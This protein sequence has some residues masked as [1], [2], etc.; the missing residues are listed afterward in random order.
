VAEGGAVELTVLVDRGRGNTAATGEALTVALS[1]APGDAAQASTYRLAPD[2]VELPAVTPPDGSQS[3]ATVV[4]LEA[5][6][7]E[8]VNDD[9][10]TLSLVTTGEAAFGTGSV[11][12]SFDIEVRDTTVKQIAPRPDSAVR[13][14]FDTARA[15]AAGADGL[16]P[17]EA[18]SVAVSDLFEGLAPGSTV[19]YSATSSDPSVRVSASSTT[20]T[21]S[22]V[23]AGSAAVRVSARVTGSASAV[24]QTR[25]NEAAVSCHANTR[26]RA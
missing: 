3:A 4:R 23:S 12:G 25:S 17:G 6:A 14:A 11:A 21:V 15:A 22:A 10:L 19:A 9:R 1:L 5:L 20:V 2:R 13:Q 24:V 18:F 8:W 16:N 7:D 26:S